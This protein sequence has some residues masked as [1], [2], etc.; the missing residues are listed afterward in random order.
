MQ[1]H[2][3][4]KFV[5]T[6]VFSWSVI[7]FFHSVA[8]NYAGLV[9]LRLLLGAVEAVIVPAMEITMGMSFNREEH[10]FLQPVLW[11]SCVVAP[12]PAGFIGYGLL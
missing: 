2:P 4:G 5:G 6:V 3:F 9:V 7:V 1:R 11:I 8:K 10:S 12:I